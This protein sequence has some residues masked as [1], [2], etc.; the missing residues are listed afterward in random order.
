MKW[1]LDDNTSD[2]IRFLLAGAGSLLVLRLLYSGVLQFIGPAPDDALAVACA[3]FHNGY[4]ITDPHTVVL[5]TTS[6]IGTR[7]AMAVA[8][9]MLT[10]VLFAA[11][12]YVLTRR[13]G[14]WAIRTLRLTLI[15]SLCWWLFAALTRPVT[16]ARLHAGGIELV[17][18]TDLLGQLS[19][20]WP[21]AKSPMD[22]TEVRDF[23]VQGVESRMAVKAL[24]HQGDITLAVGDADDTTD[25]AKQLRAWRAKHA[26]P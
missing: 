24:T 12:V 5:N 21:A 19:L 7:L 25:L 11:L 4:W 17:N 1:E 10:A 22:W 14:T 9:S 8:V 23:T 13:N 15:L 16:H 20:P 18:E 6:G 26:Q 2:G 3:R